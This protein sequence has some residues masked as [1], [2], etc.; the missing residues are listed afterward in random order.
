[1]A[2]T[3]YYRIC[4]KCGQRWVIKERT[5]FFRGKDTLDCDCGEQI[6]SWNGGCVCGAKKLTHEKYLANQDFYDMVFKANA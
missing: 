4:P 2:N 6:F 3:T 1:M 5:R